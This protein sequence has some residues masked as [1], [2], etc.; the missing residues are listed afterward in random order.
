MK[1]NPPKKNPRF[2][3]HYGCV[4]THDHTRWCFGICKPVKGVGQCGRLYPHA[5]KSRRQRAI[6][7][8]QLEREERAA[9]TS[10][11]GSAG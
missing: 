3:D 1:L 10:A 9:S 8:W 5:L 4:M 7:R 11:E 2:L 6:R